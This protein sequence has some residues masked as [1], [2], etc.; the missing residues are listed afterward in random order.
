MATRAYSQNNQVSN[1]KSVVLVTWAGLTFATTDDGAPISLAA[2]SEKTFQAFGTFGASGNVVIEGSNDGTNWSPISNRQGVTPFN[3]TSS[4]AINT[5][6][7]RPIW[8]RPRVT[9]GD[10][11]TNVTV[12]VACHRYNIAEKHNG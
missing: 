12:T 10:D 3:L 8:V 4:Q 1:D 11:T 6:Q 9:A 5:S 7:D 2:W